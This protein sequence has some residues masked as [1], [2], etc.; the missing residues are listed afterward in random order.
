MNA[1][2]DGDTD[3][4]LYIK[5][6]ALPTDTDFDCRQLGPGQFGFC[7]FAN[8][9][10]GRW[11]ARVKREA[12]SENGEYQ[13]TLNDRDTQ[14]AVCS[15]GILEPG[16][17]CDGA[18]DD[19]CPGLCEVGCTCPA[20]VCGNSVAESGEDC[21]VGADAACPGRCD[22]SCECSCIDDD[23]DVLRVVATEDR[24]LVRVNVDSAGG[25]Y[26]SFNPRDGF[27]LVLSDGVD[28]VTIEL[29]PGDPGWEKSAC[30]KRRFKW[31]GKLNGLGLVR[32]TDKT[33]AQ[34]RIQLKLKGKEVPGAGNLDP[35]PLTVEA[36]LDGTCT[37]G[38]L[39]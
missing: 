18:D 4:T 8:P 26:A 7:Q 23:L 15:N 32:I 36:Y 35:A 6:G 16:E 17:T 38:S 14:P 3:F 24:L 31:K 22:G 28:D 30:A 39:L 21:D 2:D 34:G 12:V 5:Q 20:P 10:G 29:P 13:L 37:A 19:A 25:E 11:F 33:D 9:A 27:K 1:K